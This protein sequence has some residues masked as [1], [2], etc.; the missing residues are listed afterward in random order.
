MTSSNLI[1]FSHLFPHIL[2]L[3][4]SH[5][6]SSCL[7]SPLAHYL[8]KSQLTSSHLLNWSNLQIIFSQLALFH[9]SRLPHLSSFHVLFSYS[10]PS[11]SR[12]FHLIPSP[13]R[14]ASHFD[15][16]HLVLFH[17]IFSSHFIE[18][19]LISPYILISFC[20]IS[21]NLTL[22]RY[23]TKSQLTVS[24]L[25]SYKRHL[26]ISSNLLIC[27]Q[28]VLVDFLISSP[29]YISLYLIILW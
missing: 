29:Y 20:L 18:S 10:H 28:L 23:L 9:L 14:T 16:Y 2:N 1:S 7:I 25:I 8:A 12:L 4:S 17:L 26:L 11:S 3:I 24:Q 6:V 13:H 5:S 15:P 19:P 22:A 27:S 21:S